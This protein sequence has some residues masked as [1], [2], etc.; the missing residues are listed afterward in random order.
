MREENM[1]KGMEID[2]RR[3]IKWLH[4]H[5][6]QLEILFAV[7]V[8]IYCFL[9]SLKE[10]YNYGPDEGMRYLL[11]SY[12]YRHGRLPMGDDPEVR[13]NIWG[14]SYAYLPFWLEP[15]AAVFFMHVFAFFFGSSRYILVLGA[16]FVSVLCISGMT[17]CFARTLDRLFPQSVKWPALLLIVL[18]PQVTFI[19][20]YVN[21]DS[22]NLLGISMI[23]LSWVQGIQDGWNVRNSVLLSFGIVIV[24]LSYYFG[25]GWVL[26]SILI[27]FVSHFAGMG[28]NR[29]SEKMWKLTLLICAIVLGCTG[30]FLIRNVVLYHDLLGRASMAR[31]QELYAWHE[32]KPSVH[33]S[34]Q[35]QGQ[36]LAWFL[37]DV[38]WWYSTFR[39]FVG[40]FGFMQFP[41]EDWILKFYEAAY[42]L[43]GVLTL[44][45]FVYDLRK[46]K[47]TRILFG[48][49]LLA[50]L[51]LGLFLS[52]WYSYSTDYQAQGRYI[53]SI[54]PCLLLMCGN[55][56][57]TGEE[58]KGIQALVFS[59]LIV[60]VAGSAYFNTFLPS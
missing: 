8:G 49:F 36:S 47:R 29:Y 53:M 26:G 48:I 19:G 37:H 33:L 45:S 55:G 20:S 41:V 13:H 50:E 10:S 38:D 28:K 60:F 14:F 2:H 32:F 31:D 40:T 34:L 58:H 51:V 23:L 46:K 59:L 18:M 25:Y 24:V 6:V 22:V 16:R 7:I 11:P 43:A 12:I 3:I 4:D 39:S 5:Q 15:L 30:Y 9:W 56:M 1:Q 35:K 57:E 44:V 21:Q 17:F 54:L 27:F 42:V 52:V